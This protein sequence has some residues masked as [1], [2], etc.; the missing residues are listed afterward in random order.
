[1][2]ALHRAG[3]IRPREAARHVAAHAVQVPAL[4]TSG[5]PSTHGAVK[6]SIHKSSTWLSAGLQNFHFLH[7]L[8]VSTSLGH[9]LQVQLHFQ[10]ALAAKWTC[11]SRDGNLQRVRFQLLEIASKAIAKQ[12]PQPERCCLANLPVS[13]RSFILIRA[14]VV[15][16]ISKMRAGNTTGSRCDSRDELGRQTIRIKLDFD[17][18]MVWLKY[19]NAGCWFYTKEYKGVINSS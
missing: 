19:L 13:F 1:M 5:L 12:Q 11:G 2:S 16:K 8:F 7:L 3:W 4:Y 9:F 15:M 18:A 17:S 6:S 14:R 10:A